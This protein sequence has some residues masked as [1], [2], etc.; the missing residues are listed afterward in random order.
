[1]INYV[2]QEFNLCYPDVIRMEN[3]SIRNENAVRDMQMQKSIR[4]GSTGGKHTL[5]E[6]ERARKYSYKS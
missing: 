5:S 2:L 1:M 4:T 3:Q 6:S